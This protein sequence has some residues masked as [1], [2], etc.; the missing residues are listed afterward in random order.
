MNSLHVALM[1]GCPV[2]L[3]QGASQQA[4]PALFG[5]CPCP[6]GTPENEPLCSGVN[7]GC[8]IVPPFSFGS[9]SL[10][11]TI[12][13]TSGFDGLSRDM[14]WFEFVLPE[15]TVV[16]YTGEAEFDMGPWYRRYR[17]SRRVRP[18]SR[19][20]H[21]LRPRLRLWRH[22]TRYGDSPTGN[23]VPLRSSPVH[24]QHVSLWSGVYGHP[25]G[26]LSC[27]ERNVPQRGK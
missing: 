21:R 22:C 20:V 19:S 18:P 26:L 24:Q 9:I 12:C 8:L 27:G 17:W 13:G 10:G 23:L 1:L 25:R 5:T 7:D 11:E 2:G 16:I 4:S 15:A 3:L 14:D 6:G